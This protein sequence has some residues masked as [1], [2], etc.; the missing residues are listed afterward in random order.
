MPCT[1]CIGLARTSMEY[2]RRTHPHPSAA[3]LGAYWMVE[4]L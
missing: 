2:I 4:G 3:R 1:T